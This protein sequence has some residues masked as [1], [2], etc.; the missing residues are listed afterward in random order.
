MQARI[1]VDV[2]VVMTS[3]P[4][5]VG[6]VYFCALDVFERAPDGTPVVVSVRGEAGAL[7]FEIDADGDLDRNAAPRT[8]VSKRWAAG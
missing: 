8:I 4:E 5:I 2:D 1:D 3:P 6:A 7:A